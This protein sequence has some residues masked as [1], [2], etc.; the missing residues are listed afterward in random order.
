MKGIKKICRVCEATV[1]PIQRPGIGCCNCLSFFHFNCAKLQDQDIKYIESNPVG[2]LCPKCNKPQ[3]RSFIIPASPPKDS[4]ADSS[5]GSAKT[6]ILCKSLVPTQNLSKFSANSRSK[7][8]ATVATSLK[9]SP[10]LQ[11]TA[12]TSTKTS[13]H[14]Q[15]KTTVTKAPS[16]KFPEIYANTVTTSST[17]LLDLKKS[18]EIQLL[19]LESALSGISAKFQ[20]VQ[21]ELELLKKQNCELETQARKSFHHRKAYWRRNWLSCLA[22]RTQ[23]LLRKKVHQ[24]QQSLRQNR[25]WI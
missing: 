9:S 25:S 7:T 6:T 22:F 16:T 12:G 3:R 13:R 18:F 21:L 4:A 2:W 15:T 10:E 14:E 11:L 19:S 24:K 20:E 5:K 1:T 17:E 23:K 8:K